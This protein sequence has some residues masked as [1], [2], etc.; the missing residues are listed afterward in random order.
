MDFYFVR[1]NAH[2]NWFPNI[3][4]LMVDGVGKRLLDGRI[5]VIKISVGL[6]DIRQPRGSGA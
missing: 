5:G 3:A 6:C 4:A 1:E 2:F